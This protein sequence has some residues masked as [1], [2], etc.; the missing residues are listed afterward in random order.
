[1]IILI[2]EE[3]YLEETMTMSALNNRES[4]ESNV[5]F[6]NKALNGA[7]SKLV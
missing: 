2:N 7:K 4:G 1:M 6:E 5:E 3:S